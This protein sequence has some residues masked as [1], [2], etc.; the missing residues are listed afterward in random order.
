MREYLKISTGPLLIF[1]AGGH[2]RV[3]AE[4]AEAMGYVVR[5]FID[6]A[7]HEDE[8]INGKPVEFHTLA[9][10]ARSRSFEGVGIF[11]ADSR[12]A[13]RCELIEAALAL[14][15]SVPTLVHPSA[16]VSPTCSIG[17]GSVIMAGVVIN[18]NA[19]VGRGC[20]LN[21]ACS[22]DHDNVLEAGVQIG[23]GAHVAG[24]VRF[25]PHATVGTGASL[26]PGVRI[27]E[28]AVVGAGAVVIADVPA[29]VTVVGN[30]ARS[31]EV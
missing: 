1:S 14:G 27:G 19:Q 6:R 7:R 25:G 3:V 8:R 18:A 21:T 5:G 15:F 12:N 31:L 24:G 4:V 16:I 23:P 13:E 11:V 22:I 26:I 28:R 17:D 2:G 30:P 10:L 9:E 29:G 20:I